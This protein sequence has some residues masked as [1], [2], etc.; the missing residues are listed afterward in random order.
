[1]Q[2]VDIVF[3][4]GT[5]TFRLPLVLVNELQRKTGKGIGKLFATV[6]KGR[7]VLP[8]G[9]GFG[10]PTEAEYAVG[11]LLETIRLGLLGGGRG[12]VNGEEVKVDPALA[13]S[14]METYCYPA[15]PLNEAWE[16]ATAI[17]TVCCE[18]YTEPD[19]KKK[20]EPTEEPRESPTPGDGSITQ[21]PSPT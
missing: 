1:M 15:R 10:M 3:G 14:L 4:D 12:T 7:Y 2:Q 9:G 16:L 21:E 5:Y 17:L 19:I 6:L 13:Q 11:D 8:D 18:G 20:D